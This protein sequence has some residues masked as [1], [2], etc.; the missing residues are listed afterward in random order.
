MFGCETL[1]ENGKCWYTSKHRFTGVFE[2]EVE[3][4]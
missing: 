3:D 2:K 1:I 4:N